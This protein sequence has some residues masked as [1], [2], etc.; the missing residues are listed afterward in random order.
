MRGSITT[1]LAFREIAAEQNRQTR[2][3]SMILPKSVQSGRRCMTD[4]TDITPTNNVLPLSV[5]RA[6]VILRKVGQSPV[7]NLN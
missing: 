1:C 2:R 6:D 7:E 3:R 5:R 4:R